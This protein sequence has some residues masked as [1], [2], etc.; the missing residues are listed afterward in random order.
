MVFLVLGRSPEIIKA[1]KK[2]DR[3]KTLKREEKK[4][5]EY[6][7]SQI[8]TIYIFI[9]F[10]LYFE[11]KSC[12]YFYTMKLYLQFLYVGECSKH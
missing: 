11:I 1:K 8:T 5:K 12:L 9:G 7:E 10:K 4:N 6:K 3:R 2:T